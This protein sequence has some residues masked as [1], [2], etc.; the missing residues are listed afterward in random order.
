MQEDRINTNNA[1]SYVCTLFSFIMMKKL[2]QSGCIDSTRPWRLPG[3][4]CSL[5]FS[6][7]SPREM[8]RD[9][10]DQSH[11]T[12]E[13]LGVVEMRV[14]YAGHEARNDKTPRLRVALINT[15]FPRCS[16]TTR[17]HRMCSGGSTSTSLRKTIARAI[18]WRASW[19]ARARLTSGTRSPLD[20]PDQNV[21]GSRGFSLRSS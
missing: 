5:H 9:L 17:Q 14:N 13:S 8:S 20:T 21:G 1:S 2:G 7:P 15:C 12:V 4:R 10:T 11:I 16:E 19:M 3:T 18:R 6:P